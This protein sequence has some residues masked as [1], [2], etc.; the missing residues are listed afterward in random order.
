MLAKGFPGKT[1]M[2][3]IK[4]LNIT[5]RQDL[6]V[7]LEDF[8]CTLNDGDKAVII[9]EEGNGKSTLLKW[10]CRP[11]TIEGYCEA[12]GELVLNGG[13]LGYL[14]QELPPADRGLTL[15]EFFAAEKAL[16]ERSPRVLG[17]LAASFHLPPGFYRG[18]QK[19]GTLSGGE[20]VKAQ[21]L[22]LLVAEPD[23]LLL[24]EPSN[25]ID[26]E[27]LEWLEKLI[28]GWPGIALFVSHDETLIER[29]ANMIIHI[30]HV[31]RKLKMGLSG[32]NV[33][34]LDEPTRNFSPLS[35]A[36]IRRILKEF[37][38]AI[39]SVSHDRKFL[40]EVCD[41]IYRLTPTGLV[42]MEARH[43]NFRL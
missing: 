42:P 30:E 5:H 2:L 7:I 37:P 41:K 13:R 17:R 33:L 21:M 18:G 31:C 20:R 34:L 22:R 12:E 9:G 14:P 43:A 32:A 8:N 25:D 1:R 3:Q 6:R 36:V 15:A 40:A 4:N 23:I 39:I 19:L 10:L 24:D 29:A 27:T 26:I 28:A 35:G 38:G 11:E 16:A